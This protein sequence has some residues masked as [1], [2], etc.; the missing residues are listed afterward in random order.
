[1]AVLGLCCS[2][3][4]FS[5]CGGFSCCRAQVLGHVGFRGCGTWVPQLQSQAVAHRLCSC[6]HG[7][8]CSATCGIFPDPRPPVLAGRF[9]ITGPRGKSICAPCFSDSTDLLCCFPC[10]RCLSLSSE[11]HTSWL[12]RVS[13]DL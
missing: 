4:A 8:S 10:P 6:A 2:S 5:S 9:L 3:W 13:S 12:C 1:M 11:C 7:L